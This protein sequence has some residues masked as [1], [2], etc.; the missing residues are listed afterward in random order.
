MLQRVQRCL[1]SLTS[2]RSASRI[3]ASSSS[4][5]RRKEQGISDKRYNVIKDMLYKPDASK[6]SKKMTQ[7]ESDRR[8]IIERV[9]CLTKIKEARRI[10]EE[11]L[12]KYRSMRLAMEELKKTDERL[13]AGTGAVMEGGE[14]SG[15]IE[16]LFPRR[17][18]VPTETPP[19]G[20]WEYERKN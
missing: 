5:P 17:L 19:V 9:W 14:G 3:A 12:R 20:G 18:K 11:L 7:E 13:F 4:Q 15:K 10:E 1:G 16:A 6:P 2:I 8:E